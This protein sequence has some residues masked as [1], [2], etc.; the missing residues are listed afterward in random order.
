MI[1]EKTYKKI[2]GLMGPM[3]EDPIGDLVM[4]H[5]GDMV[6]IGEDGTEDGKFKLKFLFYLK[7]ICKNVCF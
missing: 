4:A 6:L 5:I 3:E 1:L 2:S 7:K